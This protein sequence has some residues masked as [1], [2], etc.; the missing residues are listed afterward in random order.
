MSTEFW[1]YEILTGVNLEGN[2]VLVQT[3]YPGCFKEFIFVVFLLIKPELRI[4]L[5]TLVNVVP[6]PAKT[7]L[8]ATIRKFCTLL[9]D[10]ICSDIFL[11]HYLFLEALSFP[12]A[13]SCRNN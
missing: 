3:L 7:Y 10:K 1:A 8:K 13:C 6:F 2:L 11:D 5:S 9:G 12:R 4:K